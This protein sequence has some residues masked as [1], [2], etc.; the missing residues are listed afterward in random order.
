[1][2]ILPKRKT[3]IYRFIIGTGATAKY[4]LSAIRKVSSEKAG[5]GRLVYNERKGYYYTKPISSEEDNE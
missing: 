3:E 5:P 1:M 4:P 2:S